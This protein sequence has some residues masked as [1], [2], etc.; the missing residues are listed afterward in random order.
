MTLSHQLH[1]LVE[2]T[3]ELLSQHVRLAKLELK[4]DAT[5]VGARVGIIAT[6]APMLLVGYIFLCGALAYV[7]AEAWTWP[8]SLLGVGVLNLLVGATGIAVAAAQL[9]KRHMLNR[10][11]EELEQ[12]RAAISHPP[13]GVA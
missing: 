13:K 12:T 2:S 6:F 4:Q 5:Y 9:K 7:L 3:N 11:V 8:W 1:E 10:T